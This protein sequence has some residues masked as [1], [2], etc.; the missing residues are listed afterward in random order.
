VPVSGQ[1]RAGSVELGSAAPLTNSEFPVSS[2]QFPVPS[3]DFRV[4]LALSHH[5]LLQEQLNSYS[6][7]LC[8]RQILTLPKEALV[9]VHDVLK[10]SELLAM[11]EETSSIF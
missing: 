2:F 3:S 7:E 5:L 4:S 8:N 10:Y 11:L 9:Q 1:N 6:H